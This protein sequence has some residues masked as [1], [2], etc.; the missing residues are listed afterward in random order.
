MVLEPGRSA[1]AGGPNR[2]RATAAGCGVNDQIAGCILFYVVL[3][4]WGVAFDI[5]NFTTE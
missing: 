1:I 5:I 3:R 2:T 4:R